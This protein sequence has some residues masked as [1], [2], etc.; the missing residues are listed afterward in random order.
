M[1]IRVRLV[2]MP[3]ET[4]FAP[5]GVLG[6]CLTRTRFFDLLWQDVRLAM[7]TVW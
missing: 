3:S 2:P 4:G 6:Y 5:L 1:S 7:K